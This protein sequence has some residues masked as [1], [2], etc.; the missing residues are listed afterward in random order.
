MREA[1]K[2]GDELGLSADELAFYDALAD[3]GDVKEVMGDE[4]LA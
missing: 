4:V 1:P 3:H 2:R